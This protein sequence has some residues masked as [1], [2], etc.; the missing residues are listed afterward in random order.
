V[1]LEAVGIRVWV[2][3]EEDIA[4][5]VPVEPVVKFVATICEVNASVPDEEGRVSVGFPLLNLLGI[6]VILEGASASMLQKDKLPVINSILLASGPPSV[7]YDPEL[8]NLK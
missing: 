5:V 4:R 1:V 2:P 8:V 7:K 3:V 6:M